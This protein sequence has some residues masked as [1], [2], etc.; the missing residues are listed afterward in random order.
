MEVFF[1]I[2][3]GKFSMLFVKHTFNGVTPEFRIE[4]NYSTLSASADNLYNNVH[5]CY[6]HSNTHGKV[7]ESTENLKK[8]WTTLTICLLPVYV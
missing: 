4:L 8:C 5:E 1:H 3:P 7:S 2:N 6:L